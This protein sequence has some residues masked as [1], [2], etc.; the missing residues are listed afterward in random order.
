M[1]EPLEISYQGI[2]D[3]EN[4]IKE[5][6]TDNIKLSKKADRNF[7]KTMKIR[8]D[9]YDLNGK[10]E[11]STNTY[12]Y[13]KQ[14]EGDLSLNPYCLSETNI[15]TCEKILNNKELMGCEGK[16]LNK[17]QRKD[18]NN[19][20]IKCLESSMKILKKISNDFINNSPSVNNLPKIIKENFSPNQAILDESKK[21]IEVYR[22]LFKNIKD[23]FQEIKGKIKK[24]REKTVESEDE[25]LDDEEVNEEGYTNIKD[26]GLNEDGGDSIMEFTVPNSRKLYEEYDSCDLPEYI[27]QEESVK[28]PISSMNKFN[29]KLSTVEVDLD[30]EMHLENT[31]QQFDVNVTRPNTNFLTKQNMKIN[32]D[33]ENCFFF[34]DKEK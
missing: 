7:S 21:R 31:I 10:K 5:N 11:Y 30:V 25:N 22:S 12:K 27:I 13:P 16:T 24:N 1:N 3:K 28:K 23:I 9:Q 29:N 32:Y 14:M 34:R 20:V 33:N 26:H 15:I 8:N 4:K 17:S 2:Q 19:T 18:K 6:K